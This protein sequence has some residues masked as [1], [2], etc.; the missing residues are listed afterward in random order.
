MKK[1]EPSYALNIHQVQGSTLKSY[2][3]TKED[4]LFINGNV[5]YT[6]ISR[7]RQK[8]KFN[9]ERELL[10]LDEFINT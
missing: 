6:T 4:N 1:F 10:K 9:L 7:L 8:L 5:A 3:W 2:F